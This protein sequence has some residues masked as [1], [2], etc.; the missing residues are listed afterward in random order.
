LASF[1]A[2]NFI[3]G[4]WIARAKENVC[5][6][7]NLDLNRTY[8]AFNRADAGSPTWTPDKYAIPAPSATRMIAMTAISGKV[9]SLR[10]RLIALFSVRRDRFC[11]AFVDRIG[12][13]K[14]VSRLFA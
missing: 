14:S 3:A 4:R 13:E 1:P 5:D 9:T 2:H 8:M 6:H 10:E 11:R 7:G 12:A